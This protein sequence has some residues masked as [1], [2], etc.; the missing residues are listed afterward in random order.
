MAGSERWPRCVAPA[1]GAG[2]ALVGMG[3]GRRRKAKH[4][5]AGQ[6]GPTVGT[7]SRARELA[8]GRPGS[9]RP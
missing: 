7:P 9:P 4:L 2:R 3:S 8:G 6:G 5:P 1:S